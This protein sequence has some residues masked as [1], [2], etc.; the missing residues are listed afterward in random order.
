V[1][2]LK[3]TAEVRW[4]GR[5]LLFEGRTGDAAPILLD[6]ESTEGPS[7]TEALLMSIGSCMAIDIRVILEKSRVPVEELVVEMSGDRAPDPPKRFT[8]ITMDVRV[9]GPT[10]G[11]LPKVARAAQLSQDKY[12]SVFHTLR[13]DIE[14]A[15][16]THLMSD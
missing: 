16:S 12:C 15:L 3:R 8:R 5:D 13:S 1:T 11:D 4:T 9:K 10:E 7:P 14:V 6:S 2:N